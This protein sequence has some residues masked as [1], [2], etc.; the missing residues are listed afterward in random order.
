MCGSDVNAA[1]LQKK[2]DIG[3]TRLRRLIS[4]MV[5]KFLISEMIK[6]ADVGLGQHV[7]QKYT[8]DIVTQ[9]S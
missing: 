6:N 7:E 2:K 4:E 1:F 8:D 3:K 9:Y 5:T